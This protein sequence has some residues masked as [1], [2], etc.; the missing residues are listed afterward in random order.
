MDLITKTPGLQH[1]AE[2]IFSNLDRNSLW[3]CQKVNDYWWNIIMKPLFW[4]KPSTKLSE[5][6]QN[7]WM[8][9]WQKLSKRNLTMDMTPPL[10]YIYGKLEDS[11]T[12]NETYWIAITNGD[13]L[14]LSHSRYTSVSAEIIR[15]MAPL[16]ENPN[17]PDEN[18]KSP[19]YWAALKE[20]TE[21][22]KILAPLTELAEWGRQPAFYVTDNVLW[23]QVTRLIF[24]F[25][26]E[27]TNQ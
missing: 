2:Q 4:L 20:H 18:G 12:L 14:N 27:F 25:M 8:R 5:E 21:I 15:I 3:Q 7:E 26:N 9:F 11:V 24:Y 16:F 17:T 19:I 13:L 1:I 6:H 10:N 23:G 22:V